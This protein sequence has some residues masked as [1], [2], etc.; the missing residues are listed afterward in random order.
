MF[1]RSRPVLQRYDEKVWEG[2]SSLLELDSPHQI[3]FTNG[4]G[5]TVPNVVQS[6]GG[7]SEACSGWEVGAVFK[8][9]E[10]D[11]HGHCRE[12]RTVLT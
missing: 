12:D 7:R 3:L 8:I 11:L 6:L 5:E 4:T 2:M 1:A 9:V 10:W